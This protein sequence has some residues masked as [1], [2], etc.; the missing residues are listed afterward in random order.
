MSET[1]SE[2]SPG[3]ESQSSS[4]SNC[5]QTQNR[6]SYWRFLLDKALVTQD[7]LEWKYEGSGTEEDPFAVTWIENDPRNPHSIPFWRKWLIT[8]VL[9]TTTLAAA[10]NSSSYSGCLIQIDES[11]GSSIEVATLGLSLY[12]L[13]FAVGPI[14]WAPLGELY[15]RQPILFVSF[16]ALSAFNAGSA[17]A[18]NIQTLVI[19][20]FFAGTF[21]AS[22]LTNAG[23]VIADIFTATERGFAMSL[24]ATAPFLGPVL[25][26]IVGGFLGQ[27]EGWRW[28]EGVAAIFTGILWILSALLIPE[29]YAPVLLQDRAS[30]LSCITGK[31]Y[32][33]KMQLHQGKASAKEELKKALSRPW[34]LM[35]YEPIVLLLSVFMSIVYGTLY[36]F[37]GA[38]P[39]VYEEDRGWNEGQGGLA[40]LSIAVGMVVAVGYSIFDNKRYLAKSAAGRGRPEERLIVAMIGGVAVPISLFWYAWTDSPSMPWAASVCAGVVFGFGMVLIFI[41]LKNYL[42]DAYTIFAASA[43]AATVILRSFFGA[44]FPLFTT[45]MYHNIGIHWATMVPAFLSLACAPLPFVFYAYGERVRRRC[46]YAAQA[47]AFMKSATANKQGQ[48]VNDTSGRTKAEGEQV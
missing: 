34:L 12:V 6:I 38:L 47:D 44:A 25:G 29:T 32:V 37:F 14:L 8:A 16:G 39:I 43:L 33:S 31:K 27:S 9:S 28:V 48:V 20:R 17:G 21:G 22:P 10:F 41:S 36:L 23:A 7:V 2:A 18:Q 45:Y 26:P 46:K 30:K 3:I 1:K 40:F 15:G 11:F 42:V 24:F 35:F 13:G 5:I 4:G 19:L